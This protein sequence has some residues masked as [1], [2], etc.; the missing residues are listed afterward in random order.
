MDAGNAR[1]ADR[2]R[3]T[4][5]GAWERAD[6]E[7]EKSLERG[8]GSMEG[9]GCKRKGTR[10]GEEERECDCREV[11]GYVTQMRMRVLDKIR[12]RYTDTHFPKNTNTR[13]WLR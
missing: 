12:I 10:E 1:G 13:I 9:R 4:G 8:D 3:W 2:A 11:L 5:K 6:G 7:S